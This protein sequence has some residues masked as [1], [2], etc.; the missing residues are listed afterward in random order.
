MAQQ[1]STP[2]PWKVNPFRAQVDCARVE[3]GDVDLI[4]VCKMLWPTKLRTED[5]TFANAAL[6]AEAPAMLMSLVELVD[7]M[8]KYEMDTD[9]DA[10][11]ENRMMMQRADAVI[12]AARGEA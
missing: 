9:A 10:P 5:E 6:I 7:L 1:A 4:P 12:A 2:G 8:R 11:A 3:E